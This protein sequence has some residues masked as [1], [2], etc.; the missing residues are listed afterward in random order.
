MT[1]ELAKDTKRD[2][3]SLLNSDA[4]RAQIARALPAHMTPD[5]FLRVA[6][7]TMLRVPKLANCD[8]T[9]F[10]QAM[11]TCSQL[12]IEPDN[13]RAYLIP[14]EN[15]KLGIIECQ[16]IIGFMGLLE[17]AKRSGE[18]ASWKA[19]TVKERD[20]FSWESGIIH[21]SINWREDRGKLEC[22]YSV[23]KLSNGEIDT[24]VMTLAEVESIRQRSRSKDSGPWVT[25]FEEMAK[26]TVIRRH[27]KRLTLSP[28]FHDALDRDDDRLAD[29]KRDR[30]ATEAAR[31]S[32]PE[33]PAIETTAEEVKGKGDA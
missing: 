11:L 8:Q 26:K 29:E 7:T 4:I 2:L 25:D 33:M 23:V 31:V 32:F 9:S 19:E 27:S 1:T 5:R 28:E 21:H 20:V 6:T 17:L 10:M 15:R 13:R 14:F 18:V 24:E 22:V 3:K 12:G 16:L 30:A